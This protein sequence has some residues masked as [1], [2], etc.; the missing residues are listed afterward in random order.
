MISRSPLG[1]HPS[2][3]LPTDRRRGMLMGMAKPVAKLVSF[4]SSHWKIALLG[5]AEAASMIAVEGR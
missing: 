1:N 4:N 3:P 2:P 5:H